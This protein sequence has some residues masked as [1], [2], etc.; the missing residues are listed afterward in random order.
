MSISVAEFCWDN[1]D[2]TCEVHEIDYYYPSNKVVDDTRCRGSLFFDSLIN[3]LE[4]L[5]P[6]RIEFMR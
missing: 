4:A 5:T 3:F 2:I 1:P 6:Y